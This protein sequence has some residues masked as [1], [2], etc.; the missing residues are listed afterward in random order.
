[1]DDTNHKFSKAQDLFYTLFHANPI[2]TSLSQ[3]EDG[4]LLD[5]NEAYLNYFGYKREDILGRKDQGLKQMLEQDNFFELISQIHGNDNAQNFEMELTR[6]SGEACSVLVS[7]QRVEIEEKE[8]L[9]SSFIDIT[10]RVRAE[11]NNQALVYELT[12]AEQKER[13]RIAQLLH[14]D[15]QQRIYAI[16]MQL[17]VLR[18]A[19]KQNDQEGQQKTFTELEGWIR[20]A[21]AIT[22]NLS[23][24]LSPP[25]LEGEGLK[26]V[27]DW[28]STQMMEQ[29]GLE[30]SVQAG[31][32]LPDLDRNLQ[33]LLFQAVR[34]LL[35]NV[36]KHSGVLR[37]VVTLDH[38]DNHAR[39]SVIDEGEGFDANIMLNDWKSAHGFIGVRHRLNLVGCKVTVISEPGR[40]TEVTIEVPDRH[41][42]GGQSD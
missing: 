10:A 20:D 36:V 33:I 31:G 9:I 17:S 27:I 34:E 19:Y 8:A 30:V 42:G 4:V 18:D 37:A 28:L 29:Y 24:D 2:P 15:L 1:M 13:Q 21:I 22:R 38:E 32:A 6:S 12:M 39:I 23:L 26:E 16:Q 11:R 40:G 14:D 5:A 35:F 41:N 7:V 3:M 25:I